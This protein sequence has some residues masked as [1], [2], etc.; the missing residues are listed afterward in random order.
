[1]LISVFGMVS[2]RLS[3]EHLFTKL[4]FVWQFHPPVEV[5]FFHIVQN[6]NSAIEE[7]IKMHVAGLSLEAKT[8]NDLTSEFVHLAIAL[9]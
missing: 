4:S 7:V 3:K 9:R 2:F 5:P 8:V 1:M 6:L